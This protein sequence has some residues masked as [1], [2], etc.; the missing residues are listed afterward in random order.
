MQ[1]QQLFFVSFGLFT[2]KE[3]LNAESQTYGA[4]LLELRVPYIYFNDEGHKIKFRLL[5]KT[6]FK[7]NELN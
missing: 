3:G 1:H 4:L 5:N 2:D 6:K 7:I